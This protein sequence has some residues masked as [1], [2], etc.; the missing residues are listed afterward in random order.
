[1]GVEEALQFVQQLRP[2][3]TLAEQ[4]EVFGR[5]ARRPSAVGAF[6]AAYAAVGLG[7]MRHQPQLLREAEGWLRFVHRSQPVLLELAVVTLLLGQTEAALAF[8]AQYLTSPGVEAQVVTAI[9]PLMN[10]SVSTAIAKPGCTGRLRPLP[11]R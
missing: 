7:V 10:W 2:Y 1:L 11:G 5:E 3:M 6:L 4:Y 9:L 8:L